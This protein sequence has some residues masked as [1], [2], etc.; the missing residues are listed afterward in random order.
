MILYFQRPASLRFSLPGDNDKEEDARAYTAAYKKKGQHESRGE[1]KNSVGIAPGNFLRLTL[2]KLAP[3]DAFAADLIKQN[4]TRGR[5]R[6]LCALRGVNGS[7]LVRGF[8]SL[9][10]QEIA[11]S[12]S[13]YPQQQLLLLFSAKRYRAI[14]FFVDTASA[15]LCF[16]NPCPDPPRRGFLLSL[17]L[18]LSCA[19]RF[20]SRNRSDFLLFGRRLLSA[21]SAL[22]CSRQKSL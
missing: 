20:F 13:A 10:G 4:R 18:S 1:G 5:G 9:S 11:R 16:T 7:S 14:A 6:R 8:F 2:G 3:S 12:L 21:S 19:P 17:A 22:R 15:L